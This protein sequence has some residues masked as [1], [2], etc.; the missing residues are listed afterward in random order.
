MHKITS[1]LLAILIGAALF[2]SILCRPLG[3]AL[4]VVGV[5]IIQVAW[6]RLRRPDVPLRAS[7]SAWGVFIRLTWPGRVLWLIGC[8]LTWGGLMTL[9]VR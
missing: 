7:P 1:V 6:R 9:F 3:G 2:P 4:L 8:I 5:V